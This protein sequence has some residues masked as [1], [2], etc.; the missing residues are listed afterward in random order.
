MERE[1]SSC[2]PPSDLEVT[3]FCVPATNF[4]QK[5]PINVDLTETAEMLPN[6]TIK[7]FQ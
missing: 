3:P 2:T 7:D 1:S 5:Y 6:L 4:K